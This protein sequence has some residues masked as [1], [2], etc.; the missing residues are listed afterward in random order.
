[1]TFDLISPLPVRE[2][3]RR[4]RDATD[5]GW[6]VSGE[7][8]VLGF[9]GDRSIRLRRR[10]WARNSPQC[11]LTAQLA[12][13][14]AEVGG[15]TRLT[16]SV[17]MHPSLRRFLQIW[18]GVVLVAAGAVLIKTVR[19]VITDFSALDPDWWL[20]IVIPLILL[21]FAF[22]LLKLGDYLGPEEPAFLVGFLE[23]TINAHP[24]DQ[25]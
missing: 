4:L 14:G 6:S 24:A 7:K 9:V 20:G 10:I 5:R 16:C 11:W 25:A 19:I 3:V 18:I 2:C 17:G 22:L 23:R 15:G 1:M 13:E 8:P 21:G 12:D